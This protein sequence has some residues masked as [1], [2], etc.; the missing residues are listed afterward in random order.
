MHVGIHAFTTAPQAPAQSETHFTHTGPV[1]ERVT[2]WASGAFRYETDRDASSAGGARSSE[3]STLNYKVKLNLGS[4]RSP[5][6]AGEIAAA[7]MA[8]A[9]TNDRQPVA[10]VFEGCSTVDNLH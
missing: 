5:T 8:L 6:R 1:L 10:L 2:I 9:H 3:W 7:L 4:G